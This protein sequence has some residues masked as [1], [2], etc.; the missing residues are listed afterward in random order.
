MS[1]TTMKN[2]K[3]WESHKEHSTH[4]RSSFQEADDSPHSY[5]NLLI[6]YQKVITDS[7]DREYD[8]NK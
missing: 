5:Y 6:H 3:R 1:A 7:Y 2:N 8:K 4:A